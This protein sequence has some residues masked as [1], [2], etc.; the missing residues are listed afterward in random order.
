V[1]ETSVFLAEP[2]GE[3]HQSQSVTRV[4]DFWECCLL[5]EI[6]A[7]PPCVVDCK[8]GSSNKSTYKKKIQRWAFI[9]RSLLLVWFLFGLVFGFGGG[10]LFVCLFLETGI[11]SVAQAIL[12][13]QAILLPL[14][15]ECW[16][17]GYVPPSPSYY[18]SC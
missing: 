14:P 6:T 12:E 2:R 18:C 8:G 1:D 9:D 11:L 17:N 15:S 7:Q 13:L 5:T 4:R 10:C 16:N 3:N